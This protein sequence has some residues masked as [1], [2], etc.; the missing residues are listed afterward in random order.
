MRRRI[1]SQPDR[2]S[3]LAGR[4]GEE[5]LAQ[6]RQHVLVAAHRRPRGPVQHDRLE[7]RGH[8]DQL[9]GTNLRQREVSRAVRA[10]QQ[11]QLGHEL[12]QIEAKLEVGRG[13]VAGTRIEQNDVTVVGEHD[14]VRG[15]RPVRDAVG[16]QL[17][18]GVPD[19]PQLLIGWLVS[20]GLRWARIGLGYRWRAGRGG[21]GA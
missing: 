3:L 6:R 16:V 4:G 1:R 19:P 15:Q 5:A 18:D 10:D 11:G 20:G 12:G 8:P 7:Q 14:V 13:H 2:R 21:P 17:E 9:I